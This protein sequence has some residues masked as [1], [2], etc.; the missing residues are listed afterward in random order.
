MNW[1]VQKKVNFV[2]SSLRRIISLQ[3]SSII[4]RIWFNFMELCL[5]FIRQLVQFSQFFFFWI[6]NFFDLSITG[7]TWVVEMSIWCIK[8]VNVSV[9]HSR[10]Y[11]KTTLREI[12]VVIYVCS[13]F[14]SLF[15]MKDQIISMKLSFISIT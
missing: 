10:G 11:V 1:S 4:R 5:V 9:L 2:N 12:L 15:I 7:E 3:H 8:I 14:P 13:I 6:S